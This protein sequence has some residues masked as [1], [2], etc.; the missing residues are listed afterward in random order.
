MTHKRH[1]RTIAAVFGYVL[2]KDGRMT[3]A[4]GFSRLAV[5]VMIACS[6]LLASSGAESA[7]PVVQARFPADV[8]DLR[9]PGG[10]ITL[11][12]TAASGNLAGCQ[13][14][15]VHIGTAASVSLSL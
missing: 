10:H 8:V 9:G 7:V 13:L 11:V 4:P 15:N 2:S 5:A 6:S 12:L 14:S 1:L 3:K